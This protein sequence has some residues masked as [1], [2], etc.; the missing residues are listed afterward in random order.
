MATHQLQIKEGGSTGRPGSAP[1]AL[2][3]VV[4]DEQTIRKTMSEV[5]EDEGF[6]VVT[7]NNG[8]EALELIKTLGPEIV[9]LD[10]WMPGWDGIETL[11]RI[12]AERPET[13]VVMVSGHA[14]IA[15]A[16]EATR[17]GALDFMEKPVDINSVVFVAKRAAQLAL[18]AR[19]KKNARGQQTPRG[20]AGSLQHESRPDLQVV[21]ADKPVLFSHPGLLTTGAAGANVGQ[22]SIK[23]SVVLYGQG[24]HSGQ[25][26]GLVLEPLPPNSGIHFSR[27][28]DTRSVPAF[29]DYVESTGFATTISSSGVSAATIEHLMSA[30]HAY[31]ITN[32]LVKCNSE[33]PIFDGSAAEFCKVIES[34]GIVEQPGDC[35]EIAVNETVRVAGGKNGPGK[36]GLEE[37]IVEPCDKFVLSYELNYP[38]PVGRQYFEYSFEGVESFKKEISRARTFGFMRDIERLQRAGLAAGGRLDNFILIGDDSVINTELRYPEELV[39]HKI[40]DCIGDLYLIGRPIRARITAKM[41]GHSDNVAI[42]KAIKSF[43]H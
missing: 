30:L 19:E 35:F 43:I 21:S 40:L 23:N 12:K 4:D 10:I 41:T 25:K 15:T 2:V 29:V 8:M 38:A 31:R 9:F 6:Q 3:L 13:Q 5:L 17:R 37:I 14:T 39:R 1:H 16:L 18:E 34:V 7:A 26:S 36:G 33:V 11:E 22:R 42:L 32:L 24:L 28:G 27:I 20:A